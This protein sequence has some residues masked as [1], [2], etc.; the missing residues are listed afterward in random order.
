[1]LSSFVV[2][3]VELHVWLIMQTGLVWQIKLG[4][5]IDILRNFILYPKSVQ[6]KR[7]HFNGI[8]V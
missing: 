5:C 3:S 2:W 1:M 6:A 8:H 7:W 4:A